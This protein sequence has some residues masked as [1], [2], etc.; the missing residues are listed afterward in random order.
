M[1]EIPKWLIEECHDL[2]ACTEFSLLKIEQKLWQN[3]LL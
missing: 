2:L 3:L 1:K